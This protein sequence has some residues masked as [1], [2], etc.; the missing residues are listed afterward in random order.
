MLHLKA[1]TY[2]AHH[3]QIGY[4]LKSRSGV[5]PPGPRNISKDSPSPRSLYILVLFS[6]ISPSTLSSFL[7]LLLSLR[8]EFCHV[9]HLLIKPLLQF[10]KTTH[11]S[12][13]Q[14][15]S[16]FLLWHHYSLSKLALK[17]C[18]YL[19]QRPSTYSLWRFLYLITDCEHP[20]FSH[21]WIHNYSII[22]TVFPLQASLDYYWIHLENKSQRSTTYKLH[23]IKYAFLPISTLTSRKTNTKLWENKQARKEADYDV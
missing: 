8:S 13:V 1:H 16:V 10:S 3:W 19:Y 18:P 4:P 2:V 22:C 5:I 7:G 15:K 11:F 6:P 20:H 23:C 21:F 12:K 9:S 14:L 17:L